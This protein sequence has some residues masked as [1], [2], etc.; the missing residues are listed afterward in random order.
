[1]PTLVK[2]DSNYAAPGIVTVILKWTSSNQI[3][4]SDNPE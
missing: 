1:M 2:D 3:E 4:D